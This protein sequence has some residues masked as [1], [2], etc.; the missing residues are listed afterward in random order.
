MRMRSLFTVLAAL[1]AALSFAAAAPA[2]VVYN[3]ASSGAGV[4]PNTT[5]EWLDA[6]TAGGKTV[7]TGAA[8]TNGGYAIIGTS[9]HD[10]SAI[11]LLFSQAASA[12]NRY[13][14]I[15][16]IDGGSTALTP[17]IFVNQNNTSGYFRINL[18][19]A[20]SSGAQ[21]AMKCQ[22]SAATSTLK[23][24]VVG[25]VKTATGAPGFSVMEALTTADTSA[26]LPSTTPSI[27]LTSGLWVA[28]ATSS[29]AY[30]AV[31]CIIGNTATAPTG[32]ADDYSAL[33]GTGAA[34]SEV[35]VMEGGLFVSTSSPTIGRGALPLVETSFPTSTPF[36][37]KLTQP[38]SNITAG[39]A[40]A[41]I[42]GFR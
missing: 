37:V 16:S 3:G 24:I 38:G 36:S 31:L 9:T 27:S 8:N 33:L 14:C 25:T 30:G 23:I 15:L 5:Y 13:L 28:I 26:T 20:I 32:T 1:A 34:G 17:P 4:N 39:N 18:P 35:A 22:S 41:Q 10:Y 21:F 12:S 42:F 2:G 19:L 11:T 7:T 40:L 29:Q 6:A